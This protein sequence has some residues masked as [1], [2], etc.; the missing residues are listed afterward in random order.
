MP[1]LLRNASQSGFKIGP[2]TI[3]MSPLVLA[4]IE[5]FLSGKKNVKIL[6]YGSGV[7]TIWF[8]EKF[9]EATIY[10]ME[11]NRDWLA[12]VKEELKSR[13][14][15]NIKYFFQEQP[16][17]YGQGQ[18]F[19]PKYATKP[20]SHKPFDFI[21]NDGGARE[22]VFGILSFNLDEILKIG[23]VYLRHDYDRF[24]AGTWRGENLDGNKI[25]NS[26]E[27]F[28]S[29][30]E[31]YSVITIPGCQ[32]KWGYMCEAGGLWRRK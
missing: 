3:E 10:S 5:T 29:T 22:Q 15:N 1:S 31:N 9:P 21:L 18:D 20:L 11:G 16:H 27:K 32:Q 7:S 4:W 28:A 14:L 6:E 19:N 13:N 17:N 25:Q 8:C 24:L 30:H 2:I 12:F 26:Y 23:G